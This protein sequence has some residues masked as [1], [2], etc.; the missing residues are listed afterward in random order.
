MFVEVGLLRCSRPLPMKH[1]GSLWIPVASIFRRFKHNVLL[2]YNT[3]IYEPI[4][5]FKQYGIFYNLGSIMDE[6]CQRFIAINAKSH[7]KFLK[8]YRE[9]RYEDSWIQFVYKSIKSLPDFLLEFNVE[10]QCFERFEIG[11]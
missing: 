5:T 10:K 9:A 1:R 6:D 8:F 4:T 7:E 3:F 2:F 11:C